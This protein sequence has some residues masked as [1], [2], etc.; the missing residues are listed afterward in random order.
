M[1]TYNRFVKLFDVISSVGIRT[2]PLTPPEANRCVCMGLKSK[3]RTGPV[4]VVFLSI[5][6]S[7]ALKKVEWGQTTSAEIERRTLPHQEF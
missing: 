4:C 2:S 1:Y 5:S 7:E 6:D 3:P